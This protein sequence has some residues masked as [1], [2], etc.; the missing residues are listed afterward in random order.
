M[1]ICYTTRICTGCCSRRISRPAPSTIRTA[2]PPTHRRLLSPTYKFSGGG[3]YGLD[4]EDRPFPWALLRQVSCYTLLGADS[5]RP[6]P[7]PAVCST[8]LAWGLMSVSH[9]TAVTRTLVH[10]QRQVCLPKVAHW[11][12]LIHTSGLPVMNKADFSPI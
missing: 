10:P 3:G 4:S 8:T 5:R 6:W 7:R 11:A 1:S 12:T 2:D 9:R